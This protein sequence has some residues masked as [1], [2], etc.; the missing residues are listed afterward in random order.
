MPMIAIIQKN[1]PLANMVLNLSLKF[2]FFLLFSKLSFNFFSTFSALITLII[3]IGV[4]MSHNRAIIHHIPFIISHILL[5]NI[6]EKPI[7]DK[8]FHIGSHSKAIIN[9][10]GIVDIRIQPTFSFFE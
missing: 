4:H 2:L 1:N 10:R 9:H 7:I 8:N 3:H 6:S 5:L